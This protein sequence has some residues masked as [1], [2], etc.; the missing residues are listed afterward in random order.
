MSSQ[1]WSDERIVGV[2]RTNSNYL[3]AG[4]IECMS[5]GDATALMVQV[6]DDLQSRI[7]VLQARDRTLSHA[8]SHYITALPRANRRG[9]VARLAEIGR[10]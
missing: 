1:L 10:N 8:I 5:R 6:R 3:I 7:A 4:D 2:A 9:A